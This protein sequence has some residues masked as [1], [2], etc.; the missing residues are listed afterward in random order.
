MLIAIDVPHE[1]V[2]WLE[3]QGAAH[4][5]T[6]GVVAGRIVAATYD[7]ALLR[8]VAAAPTDAIARASYDRAQRTAERRYDERRA[9]PRD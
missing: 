6:A 9:A 5:S 4:Y 1:V 8:R 7:D 3:D 2:A